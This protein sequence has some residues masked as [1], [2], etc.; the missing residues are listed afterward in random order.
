MPGPLARTNQGRTLGIQRRKRAFWPVARAG[1]QMFQ[2]ERLLFKRE[3]IAAGLP[4]PRRR[5]DE[6]PL[7]KKELPAG[8]VRARVSGWLEFAPVIGVTRV[9]RDHMA[10]REMAERVNQASEICAIR[11]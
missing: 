11:A 6:A 9:I 2:T 10:I 4:A 3:W 8:K 5:L 1:A 7:G